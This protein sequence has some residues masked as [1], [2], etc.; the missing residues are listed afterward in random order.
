MK[1]YVANG[2]YAYIILEI[3]TKNYNQLT[4]NRTGN[5]GNVG[6][7]NEDFTI[8][9]DKNVENT[10][11]IDVSNYDTFKIASSIIGSQSE[12]LNMTIK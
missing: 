1:R 11:T 4:I 5:V 10:F 7:F 12:I 8:R 2:G 6:W 9:F 3:D